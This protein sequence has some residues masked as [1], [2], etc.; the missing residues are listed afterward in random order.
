MD[1]FRHY[2]HARVQA[3]SKYKLFFI[4]KGR[5]LHVGFFNRRRNKFPRMTTSSSSL[6]TRGC[7]V[8]IPLTNNFPPLPHSIYN[9]RNVNNEFKVYLARRNAGYLKKSIGFCEATPVAGSHQLTLDVRPYNKKLGCGPTVTSTNFFHTKSFPVY[10]SA[11][12]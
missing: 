2:A 12:F 9:L 7:N 6:P 10:Y 3:L 5:I 1:S 4:L 11:T 8:L